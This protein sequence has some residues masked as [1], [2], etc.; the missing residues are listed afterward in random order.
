M[1]RNFE[2]MRKQV[3]AWQGSE[4]NVTAKVLIYEAF[5]EGK[6]EAP[7]TPCQHGA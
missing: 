6:L 5:V 4:L 1:Q 3:E 2:P 7:E